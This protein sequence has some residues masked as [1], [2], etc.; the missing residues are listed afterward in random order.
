L[1]HNQNSPDRSRFAQ[2]QLPRIQI[3]F[4][5]GKVMGAAA[6]VG[7]LLL[8]LG[9]TVL[10]LGEH[11]VE[12]RIRYGGAARTGSVPF[13]MQ[14]DVVVHMADCDVSSGTCS[15]QVSLSRDMPPPV[16][17]LYH[18]DPFYQN[19][20]TYIASGSTS[21]AWGELTGRWFGH[22]ERQK[23]CPEAST[24][25]TETGDVIFPCGLQAT[26]LFNDTFELRRNG[27]VLH[28]SKDGVDNP[29]DRSRM[30][31]PPDYPDRSK[32]VW[33]YERFPEV[34]SIDQGTT[35]PD[36]VEWMRP[37]A[38]PSLLKDV[39]RVDVGL[40]QSEMLTLHIHDRFPV[41]HL[42]VTKTLVLLSPSA[43]G[44]KS[45]A[46]SN[47][48]L[49]AGCLC[50][51]LAITVALINGVCKRTPGQPRFYGS[52]MPLE[53]SESSTDSDVA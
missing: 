21:G 52:R 15:L 8:I 22:D 43:L 5:P 45:E 2:Q 44:G 25:M 4:T 33:L 31:N 50:W 17:V 35:D 36:F 9:F 26:S 1:A 34:I 7:S 47:F 40:L 38:M 18:L 46:F 27:A 3:D 48:L 32:V 14:A 19:F 30:A 29:E 10:R 12:I 53:E 39:G 41:S 6:V 42:N 20:P 13:Q 49:Y 16:R 11:A 51:L 23:H 24:R 28:I 37:S